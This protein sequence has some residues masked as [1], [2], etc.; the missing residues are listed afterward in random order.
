MRKKM[1]NSLEKNSICR[2]NRY[3]PLFIVTINIIIFNVFPLFCG[4]IERSQYTSSIVYRDA[5]IS[6]KTYGIKCGY[7]YV[8]Q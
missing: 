5:F 2:E 1:I 3:F 6:H 4:C 8:T 7:F